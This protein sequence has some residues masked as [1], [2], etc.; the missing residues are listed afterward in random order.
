MYTLELSSNYKATAP[1]GAVAL[2]YGCDIYD[3][4]PIIFNL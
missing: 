4:G 1:D 2:D 3:F